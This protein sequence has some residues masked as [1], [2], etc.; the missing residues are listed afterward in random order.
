MSFKNR[1]FGCVI[2]KS[3]NSSYNADFSHQ[4][5][6]L[7]DGTVYATDKALKY[8]I[9]NYIRE[10]Y[11]DET[12]FYTKRFNEH[13]Q[14]LTL[15]ETYE[16]LF[17][18][19]PEGKAKKSGGVNKGI[20]AGNLL[21]CVDIRFFGATYAGKTNISIHGPMQINHGV[22][23]WSENNIYSEQIMSPFRNPGAKSE[24]SDATTLGR[25]A[26]LQEGHYVHH[27]SINPKN[28]EEIVELS[29]EG[30]ALS[31]N[32]I[33][34]V[35]DALRKGVSYYD[36]S[37]KAGTDNELLIW[38]KLKESS[39]V[40]LPNFNALITAEEVGKEDGKMSFD[41]SRVSQLLDKYKADIDSVEI[42]FEEEMTTL[43]NAPEMAEMFELN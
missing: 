10:M 4:P 42:Y 11:E 19:F 13:M 22:N 1:V 5:R 6:T 12:V 14:P 37:S 24:D 35:K 8:L 32:D 34:I 15:D 39:K 33:N 9:K 2:V 29:E 20:I 38:V 3:I 31:E 17:G 26:K 18:E 28:I 36:S 30:K 25:Q 21:S 16:K 7:P 43:K 23:A 40:V 41:L 27:F